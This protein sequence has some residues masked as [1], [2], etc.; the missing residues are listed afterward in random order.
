MSLNHCNLH[1]SDVA[2]DVVV[3]VEKILGLVGVVSQ[4]LL[5]LL[6]E[7]DSTLCG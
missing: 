1:F 3:L 6:S 7:S 2:R 4:K 5:K